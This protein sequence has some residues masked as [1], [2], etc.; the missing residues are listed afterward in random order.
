VQVLIQG[1]CA[2]VP[3]EQTEGE[4][5]RLAVTFKA[6]ELRV[7]PLGPLV[8]PLGWANG[9]KGP[10]GCV[11]STPAARH[12]LCCCS[13]SPPS[14]CSAVN[15]PHLHTHPLRRWVDTTYV[16]DEVRVGRG[17][18]GSIFVAARKS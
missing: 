13:Y 15:G 16:D 5:R 9:G 3:R 18:K 2:M 14:R 6:V 1:T 11:C 8:V 12:L 17:D 10:Q 4:A 7:G